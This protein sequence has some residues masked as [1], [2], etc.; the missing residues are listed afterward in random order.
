MLLQAADIYNISI[1]AAVKT[2]KSSRDKYRKTV[3][4]NFPMAISGYFTVIISSTSNN[5]LKIEL[6]IYFILKYRNCLLY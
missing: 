1:L 4:F 3:T 5:I 2:R 6:N